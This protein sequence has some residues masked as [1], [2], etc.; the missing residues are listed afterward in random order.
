[1]RILTKL[2]RNFESIEGSA[3]FLASVLYVFIMLAVSLGVVMRYV[4]KAPLI[5]VQEITSYSLLYLTFLGAGW[6][7]R[8]EGHVCM[9]F[10][11]AGFRPKVQDIIEGITS[12]FTAAMFLIITFYGIIVTVE[13]F[14]EGQYD[15]IS[16]LK[17]PDAYYLAV[18]PIGCFLLFVRSMIRGRNFLRRRGKE[19]RSS[20]NA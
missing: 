2:K 8:R 10:V 20:G 1:M 5:W 12:L 11:I 18:V 19:S 17:I 16:V 7:L 6:L 14:K 4:F 13:H 3:A 9:D 15:S